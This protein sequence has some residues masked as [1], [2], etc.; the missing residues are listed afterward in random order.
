MNAF[1]RLCAMMILATMVAGAPA[2]TASASTSTPGHRATATHVGSTAKITVQAIAPEAMQAMPAADPVLVGAG[3]IAGCAS[4]GDEATAALLDTITGTVFTLGDNAY[5]SGTAQQF[6]DC[7]GSSWGRHKARTR[8]ATGNHDYVTAGAAAYFDYFGVA[9]GEPGKGYYS[10]NLGAWHIVVLNSNCWAVGGCETNSAQYR[11]LVADLA[12]N[13]VTCTLA[14]WHHPRFSSGPHGNSTAVL[15][16]WQALYA[17]G[18][19]VVLN[20]HDHDYERFAPQTPDALADPVLGM[21]QFV[22]GSGGYSHYA[23]GQPVANSEVRNSNTYGVLKLT[24]HPASYDWLFVPEAGKTF[25]DSGS[26]VCHSVVMPYRASLPLVSM[27]PLYSFKGT[28]I[29]ATTP[30]AKY[31]TADA[32]NRVVRPTVPPNRLARPWPHND[33][34]AL[35]AW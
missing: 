19:D 30:L 13:P 22:V 23:T 10:Y 26:A 2:A 24:L 5:P 9:A 18:A 3:D 28:K 35:A 34:N 14:Y 4:A 27:A 15:P 31:K 11:W 20:G 17:A 12:A 21:R 16:F 25:S 8:P 29:E 7:Y 33:S 1:V 32:L 6:A